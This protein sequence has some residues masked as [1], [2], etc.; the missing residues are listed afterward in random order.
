MRGWVEQDDS[1]HLLNSCLTGWGLAKRSQSQG[2]L[3]GRL[4][5]WFIWLWNQLLAA[6]W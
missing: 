5:R 2:R 3:N 1:A 6:L 4:S